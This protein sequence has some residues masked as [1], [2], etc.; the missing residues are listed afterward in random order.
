MSF[1][2]IYHFYSDHFSDI[3]MGHYFFLNQTLFGELMY[4]EFIDVVNTTSVP[5]NHFGTFLQRVFDSDKD[6][7]YLIYAQIMP[8]E[9]NS[10]LNTNFSKPNRILNLINDT[11]V[12]TM[13]EPIHSI[14]LDIN[15]QYGSHPPIKIDYKRLSSGALNPAEL[16]D[17]LNIV[18]L[19][20][21]EDSYTGQNYC[22]TQYKARMVIIESDYTPLDVFLHNINLVIDF[23]FIKI[24]DVVFF[25][26]YYI[27][28]LTRPGNIEIVAIVG[29]MS[30]IFLTIIRGR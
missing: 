16:Q 22:T 4:V 26:G 17:L 6:A 19:I 13:N 3:G 18:D 29:F 10:V 14:M 12:F 11:N 7:A 28:R 1:L 25:F 2:Y 8:I 24:I 27:F 30:F 20:R 21:I 23:L 15:S 9:Y 5:S